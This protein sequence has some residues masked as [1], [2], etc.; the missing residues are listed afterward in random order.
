M[1]DREQD[2]ADCAARRRERE[3]HPVPLDRYAC[4]CDHDHPP[5]VPWCDL[6]ENPV[7]GTDE[8]TPVSR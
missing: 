1:A 7:Y 5:G 2:A 8:A 3:A 4:R 6:C